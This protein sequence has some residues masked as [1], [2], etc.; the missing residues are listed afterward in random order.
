LLNQEFSNIKIAR[1]AINAISKEISFSLI[2][3]K[4]KLTIIKLYC[5][6]GRKFKL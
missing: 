1:A 5:S 3:Y 4:T 2:I 6:K